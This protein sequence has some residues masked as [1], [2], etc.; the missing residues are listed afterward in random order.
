MNIDEILNAIKATRSEFAELF[1][2]IQIF[3]DVPVKKDFNVIGRTGNDR[4][5]FE[6]ALM[7]AAAKGFLRGFANMLIAKG[8]ENGSLTMYHINEN[9][10]QAAASQPATIKPATNGSATNGSLANGAAVTPRPAANE[11]IANETVAKEPVAVDRPR[12]LFEAMTNLRKGFSEPDIF[13]KGIIRNMK[14]TGKVCIDEQAEGTCLLVG[15]NI[16][17]TAWHVVKKLFDLQSGVP[18]KDSHDRLTVVFDDV[19]IYLGAGI[20]NRGGVTYKAHKDWN[21][22]HNSCHVSELV[23]NAPLEPSTLREHLDYIL[24]RLEKVVTL[25]RPFESLDS[26][27]K[28]PEPQKSIILFQHPAGFPMRFDANVISDE[29]IDGVVPECRFLHFSNSLPG[30][31]G[32]PCFNEEF[33]LFGIHQGKWKMTNDDTIVV[34]TG[35]PIERIKED[36]RRRNIQLPQPEPSDFT[37]WQLD[38]SH[39][40]APVIARDDLQYMIWKSINDNE[41]RLFNIR[42]ADG[43]GKSYCIDLIS[44]MLPKDR[45]LIIELEGTVLLNLDAVG[46]ANLICTKAGS[47]PVTPPPVDE[48]NSTAIVWLRDEVLGAVIRSLDA[49][50]DNKLVWICIK[51][52]NKTDLLGLHTAT[53]L[54]FLY[55]QLNQL[56]WLRIVLDGMQAVTPYLVRNR[57]ELYNCSIRVDDI[58]VYLHRFFSKYNLKGAEDARTIADTC[59]EVNP[60]AKD[61]MSQ[62]ARKLMTFATY[63]IR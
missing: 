38:E 44:F 8:K 18:Q 62:V 1:M 50:R 31:S 47:N 51:D 58:E 21:V 52:L 42:G 36:V 37:L 19:R 14:S 24:I 25:D 61:Y 15:H 43:H 63:Y 20:R 4:Q 26:T 59:Y 30:S 28:V 27:V 29:R 57:E 10:K 45:H 40:F 60:S 13:A 3:E 22:A 32:G 34:N 33:R 56:S 16:V 11:Q 23:D 49:V 6:K 35:I 9:S 5:D 39:G 2:D 54:N 46:L 41:K 48:V 55:E 53:F 7:Y 17:I 12:I